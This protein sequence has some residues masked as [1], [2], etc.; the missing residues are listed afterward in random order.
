MDTTPIEAQGSANYAITIHVNDNGAGNLYSEQAVNI[1]VSEVNEAP[2]LT[3]ISDQTVN[4]GS[5]LSLTASASDADL[6]ANTI[7]FSLVENSYG[8]V[9]DAASGE[10]TWTPTD[11]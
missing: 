2:V 5:S 3:S 1:S 4:A 6:P 8:A 10:F 11:A 7:A 9:I